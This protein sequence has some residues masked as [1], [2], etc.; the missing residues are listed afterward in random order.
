[1]TNSFSFPDPDASANSYRKGSTADTS[2]TGYH[3]PQAELLWDPI[4][5]ELDPVKRKELV[6]Q[7]NAHLLE[8]NSWPYLYYVMQMM[9]VDT[10]IQGFHPP[11]SQGSYE[12]WDHIW[13]DPS[14]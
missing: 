12:R 11:T 9:F 6:R 1:M 14:C 10:R 7:A 3:N 13:C 4:A 8:D 5:R 2:R